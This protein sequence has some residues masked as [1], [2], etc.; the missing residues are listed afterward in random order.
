MQIK[1]RK[2]VNNNINI[3]LYIDKS[4]NLALLAAAEKHECSRNDVVTALVETG[5][6]D[7]LGKQPKNMKDIWLT[8]EEE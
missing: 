3:G 1:K 7:F 5:L 4:I 6:K 2:K 8:Y